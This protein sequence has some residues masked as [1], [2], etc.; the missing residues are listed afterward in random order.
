MQTKL[1]ISKV[2]QRAEVVRI[3][4]FGP[5]LMVSQQISMAAASVLV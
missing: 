1:C 2:L 5:I 3:C 4:D